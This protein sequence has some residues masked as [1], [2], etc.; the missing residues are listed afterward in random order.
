MNTVCRAILILFALISISTPLAQAKSSA[1]RDFIIAEVTRLGGTVEVDK[2]A[3][4]LP[5]VKIDLHG[6]KVS[7]TDL[8]F[9]SSSSKNDL[10][11]LI[12]LD[13]RL[14][15]I[16]DAATVHIQNLKSLQTLNLF[17]TQ[18][19]DRGLARLKRLTELR[20]LLIGGTKVTDAGLV[21]LKPFK[22]LH[23]LSLFE[24]QVSD[25]GIDRLR[26]LESLE[27]LL[28]TGSRIS[29]AGAERLQKAMPR[30][31]FSENT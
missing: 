6:T 4:G 30:V 3:A 5:I 20:T 12:Y 1:G 26:S 9:L 25:A 28:I 2:E 27:V 11:H 23:K 16:G 10:S 8:R 13:L 22:T 31:R 29:A 14:T 18:V 17:R 15:K 21:Y 19:G 7:D 24:T